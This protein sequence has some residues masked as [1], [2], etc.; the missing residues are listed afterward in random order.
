[1]KLRYDIIQNSE[2]WFEI[3]LGK[4]S[5][6][7][8]ADLLMDKKTKGYSNLIKKIT[9][10]RITKKSCESNKFQGN[11]FT[12]RGHE[13]EPVAREDYEFRT[14]NE[15]K[16]IGVIEKDDWSLCSP[17]G[18]INSN[19]LHQIKCP[20]FN[21]QWEYLEL[22]ELHKDKLTPN[23]LMYKLSS[24]YYK[25]MQFELYVSE[26]EFNVFTSFHPSLTAIDIIV[27]RDK[28]MIRAIEIRI[29]EAKQEVKDRMNKLNFR[30]S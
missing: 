23:E 22:L 4:F 15:V 11:F 17:D 26:R 28:D 12:E 20:I 7:I 3:K 13:F 24:T 10:E 25:Q 1:M 27:S 29:K 16:I 8:C 21:T 19:M 14:F 6:S 18:L 2:E 5:A 9:E 30:I